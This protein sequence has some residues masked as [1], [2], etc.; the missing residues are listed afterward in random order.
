MGS[1]FQ[2]NVLFTKLLLLLR[3]HLVLSHVGKKTSLL[4]ITSGSLREVAIEGCFN[5]FIFVAAI[6]GKI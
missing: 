1:S 3:S 6:V 2:V 5:S 4:S